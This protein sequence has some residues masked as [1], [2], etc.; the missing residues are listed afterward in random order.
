MCWLSIQMSSPISNIALAWSW[1]YKKIKTLRIAVVGDIDKDCS[2]CK[3]AMDV[4]GHFRVFSFRGRICNNIQNRKDDIAYHP[5]VIPGPANKLPCLA[6]SL[7]IRKIYVIQYVILTP[8]IGRPKHPLIV[9]WWIPFSM[10][11]TSNYTCL[12]LI[13]IYSCCQS[14]STFYSSINKC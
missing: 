8:L 12:L 7:R 11:C 9:S 3:V 10:C 6:R 13:T 5:E 2:G 1:N 4:F 14:C